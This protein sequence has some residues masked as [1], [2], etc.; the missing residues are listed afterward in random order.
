MNMVKITAAAILHTI[1]HKRVETVYK[2][3]DAVLEEALALFLPDGFEYPDF[4]HLTIGE[5]LTRYNGGHHDG[6]RTN[7]S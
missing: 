1:R 6:R 3:G 5:L 4:S 7:H 2:C